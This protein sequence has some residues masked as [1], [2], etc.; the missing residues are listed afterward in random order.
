MGAGLFCLLGKAPFSLV[1]QH[2]VFYYSKRKLLKLGERR[3]FF[4][5]FSFFLR[6]EK[7]PA[8]HIFFF[9]FF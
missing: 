1:L 6:K 7:K 4:S 2:K 9:N 3:A 5:Y 8:I